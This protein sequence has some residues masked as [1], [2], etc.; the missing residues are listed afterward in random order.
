MGLARTAAVGV[1]V[2][3]VGLAGT[4]VLLFATGVAGIPSATVEDVGDWGEVTD[5]RTEIVSTVRIDNPNPVG[6]SVSGLRAVYAVELNGVAVAT[7]HEEG[8]DVHP[9]ANTIELRT[10]VD[11]AKLAPWWVAYVRANETIA[12]RASGEASVATPLG[13]QSFAVPAQHRTVLEDQTPIIDALSAAA[14]ELEGT[15]TES[16][17][18]PS[19]TVTVGYEVRDAYAEWGEVTRANTTVVYHVVVHNPGDVAVP[20]VPDGVQFSVEMN[21]VELFEGGEEAMT[22]RNAA[23]DAV[24]R[25]GETREV[26]LAIRMDNEKIDDWFRSHVREGEHSS[27][28]TSFRLVFRDETTGTTVR[29]PSGDA[30]TYTCEIQTG[31]LVDGQR[32]TTTCGEGS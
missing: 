7:G 27:V 32:T 30:V 2:L 24:I 22:A 17:A 19:G 23:A 3:L 14:A 12:V 13:R 26:V 6:F 1:V 25:P 20:A 28:R 5:E 8:L 9:G 11:N 15:Y 4:G 18:G 16:A 10:Y 21:G 29:V 31:L